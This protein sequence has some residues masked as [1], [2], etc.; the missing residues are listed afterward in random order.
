MKNGKYYI[1]KLDLKYINTLMIILIFIFLVF[2]SLF[3]D[4]SDFI[5]FIFHDNKWFIFYIIYM[6]LHE[7]IHGLSYYFNGAKFNRITF[8]IM[9]EKGILYCLCK[10]NISKKNILIS[11]VAPLFVIGIF[12]YIIGIIINNYTLVLLSILNIGGSAGD[13]VTFNFLRKIKNFEF[14]EMDDATGFAIYS[15]SDISKIKHSGIKY[16]TTNDSIVR[17]DLKK[18]SVS[19]FSLIILFI[20]ALVSFI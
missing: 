20:L 4:I 8:G 9:L 18:F 12:T 19:I 11:S 10:Q 6:L 1:Y 5:S 7:C 13:I 3:F 17:N 14:S 2:T 16:V 15:T